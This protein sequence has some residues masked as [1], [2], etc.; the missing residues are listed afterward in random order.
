LALYLLNHAGKGFAV[1]DINGEELD[2][3][4]T[5]RTTRTEGGLMAGIL[6]RF[7]PPQP[8]STPSPAMQCETC[9][10]PQPLAG[11]WNQHCADAMLAAVHRC[12]DRALSEG[13]ANTPA[14]KN[15][16]EV[17]REVAVRHHADRDPLL[18][19]ELQSLEAILSQWQERPKME[20]RK[21]PC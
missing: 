7:Q 1:G 2:G 11:P 18:W 20:K 5:T 14:R 12:C 13:E 4:Q 6:T 15:V 19:E 21:G 10:P 8:S 17:C 9:T 3:T 16:V